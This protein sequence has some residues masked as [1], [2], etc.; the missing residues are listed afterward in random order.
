MSGAVKAATVN[1]EI[2]SSRRNATRP[3]RRGRIREMPGRGGSLRE[4]AMGGV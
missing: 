2:G 3:A 4:R 1:G